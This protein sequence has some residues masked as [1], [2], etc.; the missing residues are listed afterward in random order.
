MSIQYKGLDGLFNFL[1]PLDAKRQNTE[2]WEWWQNTREW[3]AKL[4][5]QLHNFSRRLRIDMAAKLELQSAVVSFG[6]VWSESTSASP[7]ANIKEWTDKAQDTEPFTKNFKYAT[8]ARKKSINR[9]NRTQ[10]P[11]QKRRATLFE[12][13]FMQKIDTEESLWTYSDK[14]SQVAI[15]KTSTWSYYRRT[16]HRSSVFKKWVFCARPTWRW[17]CVQQAAQERQEILYLCCYTSSW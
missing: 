14:Q 4:R 17:L 1:D 12:T 3:L 15:G 5:T 13:S 9:P 7:D 2:K 6:P 16:L 11:E 10:Y 8:L